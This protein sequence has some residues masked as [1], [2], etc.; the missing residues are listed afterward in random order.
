AVALDERADDRLRRR[1]AGCDAALGLAQTPLA[2]GDDSAHRLQ[3]QDE[4]D[5]DGRE[6]ERFGEEGEAPDCHGVPFSTGCAATCDVT[7]TIDF[8]S[9]ENTKATRP[10]ERAREAT[11]KGG[12]DRGRRADRLTWPARR[13]LI[14]ALPDPPFPKLVPA[15][16][17]IGPS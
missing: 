5:D 6:G 8:G 13:P 10:G 11:M 7:R 9:E 12:G 14:A 15:L 4:R 16:N 2:L 1:Q 3:G 17:L